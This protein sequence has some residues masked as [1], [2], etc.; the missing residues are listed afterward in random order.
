MKRL[1]IFAVVFGVL[2]LVIGYLIFG[3][4]A[5][6]YVPIQHI[7]N[8]PDDLLGS[9][10]QSITGVI[11]VRQ[12]ILV[13]GAVGLGLGVVAAASSGRRRRR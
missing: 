9:V 3:R 11:S 6:E 5:G 2:G 1:V 12:S 10:A 13:A 8:I 4:I 7:F